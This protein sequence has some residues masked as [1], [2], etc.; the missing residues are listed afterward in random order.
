[1]GLI[2]GRHYG[3]RHRFVVYFIAV[4]SFLLPLVFTGASAIAD[5]PSARV[6]FADQRVL[7]RV[8]LQTNQIEQVLAVSA[9]PEALAVDP[10]DRS[11]WALS[12]KRLR[13]YSAEGERLLDIDVRQLERSLDN[14]EHL[15]LNPHDGSVW[16]AGNKGVLH[17]DREGRK[18]QQWSTHET[19]RAIAL[20]ADDSLWVLTKWELVHLTAQA[21][22]KE[23]LDIRRHIRDPRYLAVDSLGATI[24]VASIRQVRRFN[25]LDINDPPQTVSPAM[26]QPE[27]ADESDDR[28]EHEAACDRDLSRIVAID[29]RP[30]FGTLWVLTGEALRLYDRSGAYIRT[31][32]LKS[33]DIGR[34]RA[35][36]FDSITPA[37]W[38]A[39]K[40]AIARLT[41]NG[42]FVARILAE[43]EISALAVTPFD[44]KP[45]LSLI[46][47]S[48]GSVTR[49][50][51][52]SIRLKLGVACSG[53]PCT[54]SDT[55]LQSFSFEATLNQQAIGPLFQIE[56]GEARFQ[57]GTRLPEGMNTFSAQARDLFGHVSNMV[58]S[59]FMIDTIPPKFRILTPADGSR[60][61]KA[62]ITIAGQLDDPTAFVTLLDGAGNGLGLSGS[63][64]SFL[65]GLKPGTNNFLLTAYDPAGN[66]A[67][68]GLRLILEDEA[69]TVTEPAP[70][71]TVNTDALLLCGTFQ[72]PTNI[73]ITV[74]G[75]VAQIEGNKF[76]VNNL[77]LNSGANTLMIVMTFPDGTTTARAVNITSIGAAP[78]R[79]S[80][81]PPSGVAPLKTRFIVSR[82]GSA[83]VA[84]IVADF[85]GDGT[86][87]LTT[88]DPAAV[89]EYTYTMPGLYRPLI[90]VTASNGATHSQKLAVAVADAQQMD[91]LFATIWGDMNSALKKGDISAAIK[92]LNESAKRKYEP[93]F[94]TLKP[95]M[96]EIINSYSPLRRVSV[97][98]AIGEYAVVRSFNGQNRLYL[99]YFFRGPDGLWRVDEM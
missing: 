96:A 75:I 93:V 43:K 97:S 25:L 23:R 63:N 17:L 6:W 69:I 24:W 68:V 2:G 44:L 84:R 76:C 87:D 56:G 64:F 45:A 12:D 99:I 82:T 62:S 3:W 46:E 80:I 10:R 20:D 79:V 70:G 83:T 35:I 51:T 60:F 65:T 58:T 72:G 32:D 40:R 53:I 73:G 42:D 38:V 86:A 13:K 94:E 71:S 37:L 1:M 14:A 28:R 55:Y 29:A 4:S 39:G 52:P 27:E 5:Q 59:R 15:T 61:T 54:L 47:P 90:T 88:T 19:L 21:Q 66:Y 22:T 95:R 81:Q 57:P 98:E 91:Q 85:D 33:R 18:L 50:I 31:L 67:Q 36:A 89:L 77:P 74:N 78:F 34:L 30:V 7:K 41:D 92:H 11:L 16:I 49:N 9:E 8:S 26:A 48:D